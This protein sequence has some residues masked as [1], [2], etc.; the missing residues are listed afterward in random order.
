M[1]SFSAKNPKCLTKLRPVVFVIYPDITL[2]DLAGPLQVFESCG[3]RGRADEPYEIAITSPKGGRIKTD[4]MVSIDSEPFSTWTDR[5]IHTLVVVGGDGAYDALEDNH[6]IDGLKTL[7]KQSSRVCSVCSGALLLA[8]TGILNGKRAVT[9]WEDS[10]Q[11]VARFP[12][13]KVEADPIFVND[14]HVWTSAGVTSGIDMALALVTE[15]LGQETAMKI[16][17]SLVTYMVRPGGQSQFSPALDRQSLDTSGHFKGL[18]DWIAENLDQD[19][20][21]EQLAAQVNMSP[22]N[23]A[24]VY[25]AKVGQTPAKTVEAIRTDKACHLL[26]TTDL[27][28]TTVAAQCGFVDD[29]RMR[30]AF[31][32]ILL[33]APTD[34]RRRFRVGGV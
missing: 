16:A 29:E 10:A 9:H 22:R 26:E 28:I 33:I 25:T 32:R 13:V 11:L 30:R 23:F 6:L 4:T 5:G 17:R 14:E 3:Y 12:E 20:R 34:Y 15:D 7:I 8:A 18:H 21:V 31:L 1:S 19:L 24:R 2:L 27:P